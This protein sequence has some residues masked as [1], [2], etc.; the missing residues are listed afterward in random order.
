MNAVPGRVQVRPMTLSDLDRVIE[1]ADGLKE[2]PK[3]PRRAYL[4]V[5]EPDARPVRLALVAELSSL[6][7]LGFGITTLI[8]PQAEIETIAVGAEFQR[9][10]IARKL[11]DQ[12]ASDLKRMQITEVMLE[13]RASNHSAQAFYRALGFGQ[14]GHRIRYYADPEEDA[15]L[16]QLLLA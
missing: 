15:L 6:G 16:L 12:I 2:A 14:S 7:V 1:I 4:D 8:P 13:V 5:L 3:W 10:G 11:F 9:Q